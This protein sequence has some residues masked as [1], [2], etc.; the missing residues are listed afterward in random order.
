MGLIHFNDPSIYEFALFWQYLCIIAQ[1]HLIFYQVCC[2]C[3]KLPYWR[4][5]ATVYEN[6]A[7]PLPADRTLPDVLIGKHFYQ[8]LYGIRYFNTRHIRDLAKMLARHV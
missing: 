5:A 1:K 4:S 6:G 3:G 8:Y 2:S 7:K